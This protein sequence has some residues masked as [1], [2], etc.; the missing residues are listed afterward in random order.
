[1][2]GQASDIVSIFEIDGWLR[3]RIGDGLTSVLLGQRNDLG[4]GNL[5]TFNPSFLTSRQLGDLMILALKASKITAHSGYGERG[6]PWKEMK[7]WLLFNGV[8]IQ[9]DG[10][11]IDKGVELSF[12]VLSH[13]A[14]SPF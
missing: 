8:H 4:G 7:E 1:L 13:S 9:R 3:I 12:M 5:R 10:A 11:A 2:P 6:R 14:D